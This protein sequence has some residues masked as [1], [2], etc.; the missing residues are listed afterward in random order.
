LNGEEIRE[1]EGELRRIGGNVE[2]TI[3]FLELRLRDGFEETIV[4]YEVSI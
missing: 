1:A 3:D 4:I 2:S